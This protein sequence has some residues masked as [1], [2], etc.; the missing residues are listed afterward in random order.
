MRDKWKFN[1]LFWPSVWVIALPWAHLERAR[2]GT[3][4]AGGAPRDTH[5]QTRRGRAAKEGVVEAEVRE[6]GMGAVGSKD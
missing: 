5:V 2:P 3:R 1:F 4:S 6:P